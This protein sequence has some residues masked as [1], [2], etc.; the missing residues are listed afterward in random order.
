MREGITLS[1]FKIYVSK[2]IG[3]LTYK[4]DV[5]GEL[6]ELKKARKNIGSIITTNYDCLLEDIF[7]FNPL[8]G[9]DILL[10]NPYGSI[11]KIHK[12]CL[13]GYHFQ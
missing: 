1:R 2:L 6:D 7:G 10:S 12:D 3:N 11:Y 8:I 4:A 13:R 5:N 9:N